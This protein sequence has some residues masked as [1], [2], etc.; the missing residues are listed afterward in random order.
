MGKFNYKTNCVAAASLLLSLFCSSCQDELF[1]SDAEGGYVEEG[2]PATVTLR[3][4]VSDMDERTRT[5]AE[6]ASAN[7]CNN[8]WIGLYSQTTDSLLSH[9]Y[10]DQVQSVDEEAGKKYE[11]SFT[12]Q[13]HNNVYIVAVANS[14]VNSGISEIGEYGTETEKTLRQQ[15]DEA[16][17]LTEF[18][19]ICMLRPDKND[20]NVYANTLTMSGWYATKD[21]RDDDSSTMTA[22]NIQKG[23]NTLPGAIYL[24]RLIAYNKFIIVPGE[25]VNLTLKTWQVCNVPAGCYMFE[26][27]G[28]VTDGKDID[29]F[30][31][32]TLAS[33]LFTSATN[34]EGKEGKSFEFYQVENK[35]Q[36]I[37][38]NSDGTDHVGIDPNVGAAKWYNEREREFKSGDLNTG[39]YRSLVAST[40]GDI[41]NNNA[42]YVVLTADI[43]YYV[44]VPTDGSKYDPE[45]AEPVDPSTPGAIHRTATVTYTIHLGYCEYKNGDDPTVKTAE[46]FNCRRNTKYTYNVTING[47]K[48]IVV[49][50]VKKDGT[51]DQPGAEGQVSDETGTYQRLDSHFCE[52]NISLTDEE[53]K[54]MTYRITAPY[55]NKYY[56]YAVD[57]NGVEEKTEGMNEELY[58][59]IKFYPTKD[60]TT[61]AEYA[62]GYGRNSVDE[63]NNKEKGDGLWSVNDLI[64]NDNSFYDPDEN[65]TRWY[66]VF[67]DEYVYHFDD[68]GKEETSWPYY[69]NQNDRLIEFMMNHDV[70]TDKESSYTYCKYVFGQK[71]IQ[72][73][74]KGTS[75]GDKAIGVEHIEETYCLNMDWKFHTSWD[76]ERKYAYGTGEYNSNGKEIT[77][78]FYDETNGRYNLWKYLDY[79]GITKW[80]DVIQEKVPGHVNGYDGSNDKTYG[81]SHP[82]ADYPVYMPKAVGVS[83]PT[84]SPSPDNNVYYANSIC[85]N[86]NRDLNGNGVIDDDEIRWFLPTSSQYIQIAISQGE[87]P[88]PI[89]RFSDYS[90]EY[91]QDVWAKYFGAGGNDK[92]YGGRYGTYNFHYITSDYQYYFAEQFASTGD[93]PFRGYTGGISAAY[94]ARC[95]RNLGTDPSIEPKQNTPEVDNAF[96]YD[97]NTRIFTQHNFKD[98]T[99]RG[100]TLGGLAPHNTASVSS[101][102]YKK[103]Q[104][105]KNKVNA[106]DQYIKF[107][108]NLGYNVSISTNTKDAGELAGTRSDLLDETTAW[109]NSLKQNGICKQYTEESGKADLGTWRVPSLGEV[110]LMWIEEIPQKDGCSYLSATY[111]Y[112]ASFKMRNLSGDNHLYLGF[113]N[114]GGDRQIISLDVLDRDNI[115]L[116]CV[117]DV[118]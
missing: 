94:T 55:N 25:Y 115:Q 117:R 67:V 101:H 15:L 75:I 13:S 81:C 1:G 118:K 105:A 96:S 84:N 37:D 50:A 49:E 5:I 11:V 4:S 9:C 3:F 103:F 19:K 114:N 18:K 53:R 87:L 76:G 91:F 77:N 26:Q 6:E 7:Y 107:T 34:D 23:N 30:Y 95:I 98:E 89:F 61:L 66:T 106:S 33:R 17:T 70:A 90:T 2:L 78:R 113:F 58:S 83:K 104:V 28:N 80:S 65:G 63:A 100:Y 74:Y 22:I 16:T 93:Y 109:T 72:T 36:A 42:T 47:V 73:Y 85:M 45:T 92:Q 8:V 41:S 69:A 112:F 20:V 88:D 24:K 14:D 110:G 32:S 48:N 62:G 71:S 102:P 59:W 46:D 51:E 56:Y 99:L 21:P 82:D 52:F 111:D 29:G 79:N 35:H 44:A 116:R 12:T 86:R 27:S 39:I 40:K 57:K 97:E 43:D 68:Q 60:R 10:T 31:N 38:Y 64:K 108:L 54:N